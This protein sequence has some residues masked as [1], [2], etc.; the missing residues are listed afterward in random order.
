MR[1]LSS[2]T[3]PAGAAPPTSLPRPCPSPF[4]SG[5]C[6]PSPPR[7]RR[8]SASSTSTAARWSRRRSSGGGPCARRW[9]CFARAGTCS[10]SSMATASWGLH[11]AAL[12]LA[13][14]SLVQSVIAGGLVLLTVCAD[15]LFGFH[16]TRREW[17]GVALTAAG[18]AFLAATLDGAGDEAHNDWEPRRAG[19]LRDRGGRR[20]PAWPRRWPARTERGGND[21]GAVGRAALGS[22]RRVDQGAERQRRRRR[23]RAAAPAGAGDPRR[24]R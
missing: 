5:C 20:G 19:G 6:S 4:S 23:R 3:P 1:V 17:I 7:S 18:L 24:C 10:A 21:A 2:A 11:V 14:I 8:S 13:P 9:R 16:V 22:L 15:R 12:S